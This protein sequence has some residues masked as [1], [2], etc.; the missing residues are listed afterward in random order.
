VLTA[1]AAVSL[2]ACSPGSDPREGT[3]STPDG[4]SPSSVSSGVSAEVRATV[5]TEP[6]PH[7]GDAADDPAVWVN[8]ADP[9]MSAVI[10]TDKDGGLL[11]YD[12]AGRELQYLEAG[13]MNNVD[14]R[15]AVDEFTLGGRS[16]VLVVAGNRKSNS[17]DVFELDPAT[18][19]LRDVAGDAIEP[20]MDVYGSCLYRSAGS[21]KLYVFVNSKEGEVQQWELLDDGSGRVVGAQVRSF[22]LGSQLEGCVA[23]DELGHLYIGEEARGIWKFGAE[24]DAGDTGSLIVE[25]S[26]S[27]PLVADVEGLTI[28]RREDGTG[29]LIA[30]SQGD[31]SYAVFQ[32]EGENSYVGSFRITDGGGI[33]GTSDTD[34]IDV[35]AA[36][37]GASFPSGVFVA[38]D[39]ENDEGR[40]NFK[41]VPL[42]QILPD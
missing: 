31:N 12:L 24:P 27:G 37:M 2:T 17:V 42:D 20:A 19:Q 28:A 30:S 38:Q 23:D 22:G 8:P 33:D 16:V 10:G 21:G 40:Q 6:V 34:G 32:R 25:A 5:E 13:D 15:P 9:S 18:R 1:C 4:G 3:A 29:Y 26:P 41:L 11:V 7:G 39:G 36:P 14:I 35:A